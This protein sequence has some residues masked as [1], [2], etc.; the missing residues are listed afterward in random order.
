MKI[1]IFSTAYLPLQGGAEIAVKEITDRIPEMEFDLV[2]PKIKPQFKNYER[3]SNVNVWRVGHGWGKIDKLLFPWAG[4][5]MASKLHRAKRFNVIWAIMASFGGLAAL[6]FKKKFPLTPFILTLQEGDTPEHIR[7]RARWLGPYYRQMFS[8]ADYIT[9][10]SRYLKE[11]AILQGAKCE[12]EVVPNGVDIQKFQ[13][14]KHKAQNADEAQKINFKKALGIKEDEK[15]IITISRLVEKNGIGDLIEAL[16]CWQSMVGV[17]SA[18]LIIIGAGPLEKKLKTKVDS[19]KLN[20]QVI[21]LGD[22]S[23]SETP[24]Y[25]AIADVFVRPSL[26]EGLGNAFLEAMAAGVPV[27]GTPVGGIPD[28]LQDGETGLF[29][30]VKNPGSVAEKINL[31]LSDPALRE[32]IIKNASD[33]IEKKYRWDLIAKKMGAIFSRL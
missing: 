11:Y 1:L 14:E 20:N 30:E 3:I 22:V 5:R 10:I 8:W 26:A 27:I 4:A 32:K 18:K 33:L 29:C 24:K 15:I 13:K 17:P 2:C 12:V 23:H 25:L 7:S 9:A 16:N 31:I 21:F 28:F 19:L 6:R